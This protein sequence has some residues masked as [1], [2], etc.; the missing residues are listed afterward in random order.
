MYRSK[1]NALPDF[2]QDG[3]PAGDVFFDVRT[4]RLFEI[5]ILMPYIAQLTLQRW[6]GV[7]I[8]EC[9]FEVCEVLRLW[10][11]SICTM[12]IILVPPSTTLIF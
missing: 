11:L 6:H 8:Y 2:S 10:S 3:T 5:S 9:V 1:G 7:V 12:T 4:R